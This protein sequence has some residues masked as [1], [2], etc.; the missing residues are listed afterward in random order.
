MDVK[1]LLEESELLAKIAAGDQHA[2]KI[3]FDRYQDIL[4]KFAFRLLQEK[5]PAREI[6]QEAMLHIWQLGYQLTEINNIESYLKTV[7][8]HKANHAF[9][10][11]LLEVKVEKQMAA[12]Y[13]DSHED[14]EQVIL[15]NEARRILEEGIQLL[16]MQQRKVYQLC[17]Q[18]GLKYEEA[19]K[20][21]NLSHGTVQTHMKLALKFLRTHIQKNTDLAALLVIFKLI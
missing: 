9:R 20:L 17:Q 16:P 18:Q 8:R 10:R 19:A 4:F 11:K 6:V 13:V 21:L 5:E 3:I 12:S 14:T 2:F 1:S 15:M 7:T